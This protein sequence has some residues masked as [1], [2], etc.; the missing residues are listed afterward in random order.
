MP[1]ARAQLI[2]SIRLA[3]IFHTRRG[4]TM[5]ERISI[6]ACTDSTISAGLLVQGIAASWRIRA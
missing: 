6:F 1:R 3:G 4:K 5:R 2:S